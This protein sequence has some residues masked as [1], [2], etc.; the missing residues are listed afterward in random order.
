[1]IWFSRVILLHGTVALA[2]GLLALH[3]QPAG[4]PFVAANVFV[5]PPA[6]LEPSPYPEW[7]HY[8]WSARQKRTARRVSCISLYCIRVWLSNDRANQTSMMQYADEY[9]AHD[10][11]VPVTIESSRG[12]IFYLHFPPRW[13]LS[14]SIPLGQRLATISLSTRINIPMR[15][16]W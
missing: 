10:I 13:V 9:L 7:A 15:R 12:M 5:V 3:L 1:M 11:P 16:K 8:H 2:L 6:N 14:I 4:P